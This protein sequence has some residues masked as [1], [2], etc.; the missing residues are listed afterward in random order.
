MLV[1]EFPAAQ[2]M[3]YVS[4]TVA[5]TDISSLEAESIENWWNSA[6]TFG[7]DVLDHPPD[8]LTA[9][10]DVLALQIS[11][12]FTTEYDPAQGLIDSI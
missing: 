11:E 9:N 12:N 6:F 8:V 7:S 5:D 4:P 2:N 10:W 3:S 1:I